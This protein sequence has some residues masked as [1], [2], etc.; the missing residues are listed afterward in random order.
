M[1]YKLIFKKEAIVTIGISS[2]W[3][4]FSMCLDLY[5]SSELPGVFFDRKLEVVLFYVAVGLVSF[6][7]NQVLRTTKLIGNSDFSVM[8][9][10]VLLLSSLG[11]SA[12]VYQFLLGFQFL[13]FLVSKIQKGFNQP[14][15]I[16]PEFEVGALTGI[17]S[18]INPIFVVIFPFVYFAFV[19]VK[20]NSWRGFFAVVLGFFFIWFLKWSFL[21]LTDQELVMANIMDI[22]FSPKALMFNSWMHQTAAIL[23]AAVFVLSMNYFMKV[24]A[25][26]NI[27]IRIFY[28]V[29]IWLGLFLLSGLLL[30][31]NSM[32]MPQLLLCI[33]LPMLVLYTVWVSSLSK[34]LFQEL[35]SLVL[36][37]VAVLFKF[38]I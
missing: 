26:L 10:S 14:E 3:L 38:G 27:R 18:L 30:I 5:K 13:L 37:A 31:E 33:N 9:L 22:H 24:S 12:V 8:L 7:F 2:F 11:Q 16:F 20:V 1:F 35:A 34:K 19:N 32:T 21:V 17:L 28:K 36:I 6:Y 15:N 4:V 25:K 29:W 23:L